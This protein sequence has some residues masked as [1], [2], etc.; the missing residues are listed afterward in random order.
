ML[1]CKQPEARRPVSVQSGSFINES[2]VRN[3]AL[4]KK[5]QVL[6]EKYIA[7]Q[8]SSFIASKNG[9]WYTYNTQI[10]A[11]SLATPQFGDVVNYNYSIKTFNGTVLYTTEDIKTQTYTIDQE[12]L[13]SGLREGLKLMKPGETVTFLFPSQQAYGYYGD[14]NKIG[15]NTPLICKVTLNS[16]TKTP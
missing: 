7:Q 13:F 6:I 1:G 4:N 10:I 5:E 15:H 12:E 16:I 14:N 11:D 9:F 8:D 3:K 2:V